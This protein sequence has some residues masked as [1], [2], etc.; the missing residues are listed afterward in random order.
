MPDD[1]NAGDGLPSGS[2]PHA[3]PGAAAEFQSYA[4]YLE[5]LG[6][7]TLPRH[8]L[9]IGEQLWL[10]SFTEDGRYIKWDTCVLQDSIMPMNRTPVN[11]A[12]IGTDTTVL[13]HSDFRT[14]LQTTEENVSYR[15]VIAVSES[16]VTS[17][18]LE[19]VLGLGLDME[20]EIFDYVNST[21]EIPGYLSERRFPL[22]WV[23]DA[24]AL[25][26]G[27]DVLCILEKIPERRSKTGT[28]GD[29]PSKFHS[30][31]MCTAIIFLREDGAFECPPRNSLGSTMFASK[32]PSEM[33]EKPDENS[34][35]HARHYRKS[36]VERHITEAIESK[37]QFGPENFL[38]VCLAALLE[39][40]LST[41]PTGVLH[42][43]AFGQNQHQIL[44]R[45]YRKNAASKANIPLSVVKY[46]DL[47]WRQLRRELDHQRHTLQCM[48]RFFKRHLDY[49]NKNLQTAF[50]EIR[51]RFKLRV[52]DLEQVESQL[53]DQMAIEGIVKSIRMAEMSIRESK[54][55]MLRMLPAL[56]FLSFLLTGPK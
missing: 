13:S 40:H 31:T 20:P 46:P 15:I 39:L 42:Y 43:E 30:L 50:E 56:P 11:G 38:Y 25:R 10:A 32:R 27:S 44:M 6:R 22:P 4:Q 9:G 41:A 37:P 26:I 14:L 3:Q 34:N 35:Y 23:K 47:G 17:S 36:L 55:V 1:T 8:Y 21:T 28:H 16:V 2:H 5:R 48:T 51:E 54:R 7:S 29:A 33:R 49:R 45:K 24:P 18:I 52:Q 12:G 53:R 19:N